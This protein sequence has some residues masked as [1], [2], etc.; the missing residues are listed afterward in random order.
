MNLQSLNY[1][2]I[3]TDEIQFNHKPAKMLLTKKKKKGV[4]QNGQTPYIIGIYSYCVQ[5]RP[6]FEWNQVLLHPELTPWWPD[7]AHHKKPHS[8]THPQ[9][10]SRGD[11][12][13]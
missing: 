4:S 11:S 6:V 13:M 3:S 7:G 8:P 12:L 9:K 5:Y 2:L 10:Y 1:A